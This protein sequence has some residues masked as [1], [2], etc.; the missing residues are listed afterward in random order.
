MSDDTTTAM[1]WQV[2]EQRLKLTYRQ[3][4]YWIRTNAIDLEG[5]A[6]GSGSKRTFSEADVWRLQI[7]E[8]LVDLPV[9]ASGI[10]GELIRLLWQYLAS[11]A[12]L[13]ATTSH[14][15]ITGNPRDGW[16]VSTDLGPAVDAAVMLRIR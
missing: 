2:V 7:I 11:P 12:A 15:Y 1:T 13:A 16:T 10:P 6:Q 5:A 9:M 14:V 8:R 3:V 4:D